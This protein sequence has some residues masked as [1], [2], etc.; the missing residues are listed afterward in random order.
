MQTFLSLRPWKS[1]SQSHAVS[2]SFKIS[3]IF[4]LMRY[5]A[6]S[7]AISSRISVKSN[8]RPHD[9]NGCVT[10]KI[11]CCQDKNWLFFDICQIINQ[12]W[13]VTNASDVVHCSARIFPI[14]GTRRGYN[15]MNFNTFFVLIFAHFVSNKNTKPQLFFIF[16][17]FSILLAKFVN[18]H[19][20]ASWANYRIYSDCS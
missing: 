14:S 11:F 9:W 4:K 7:S 10:T 18:V 17:I 12:T 2:Y 3:R 8:L 15:R 1:E 19:F 20:T 5:F 13:N 16:F 6:I